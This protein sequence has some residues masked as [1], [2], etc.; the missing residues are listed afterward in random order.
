[1]LEIFGPAEK[2]HA[3]V[4]RRV[5]QVACALIR[6]PETGLS[7]VRVTYREVGPREVEW[8]RAAYRWVASGVALRADP[9]EAADEIADELG[10]TR[11]PTP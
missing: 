8:D 9:E 2:L 10:V 11:P 5:P 3:A 1:M 7:R 6:D 4:R